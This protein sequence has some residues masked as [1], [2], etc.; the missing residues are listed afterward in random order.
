MLSG[1][2]ALI[3]LGNSHRARQHSQMGE[4][5]YLKAKIP[6]WLSEVGN[7]DITSTSLHMIPLYLNF[8]LQGL[9]WIGLLRMVPIIK[10]QKKEF[11]GY[12]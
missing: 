12:M 11:C 8:L 9:I 3:M 7:F 2:I 6:K 4:T 1:A 10:C 5:F